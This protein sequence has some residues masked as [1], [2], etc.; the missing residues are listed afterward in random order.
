M[1]QKINVLLVDDEKRFRDTTARLLNKRGLDTKTAAGGAE[2]AEM[3]NEFKFDVV[4][5]DIKMPGMDGHAVLRQIKN[6][7]PDVQVIMLTG[8]G[9]SDSARESLAKD[10]FDYLNKPCDIDILVLKIRDAY[11]A[12]NEDEIRYEKRAK[13]IM[14]HIEDYTK[15]HTDATVK[16]AIMC[17]MDS[18]KNCISSSQIMETG[19]RSLLVLDSNEKI[20]GVLSIFDL[21]E[22]SRPAYLSYPK[23]SMADSMQYSSMFWSGLF[24][25]QIQALAD[26]KVEDIMSDSPPH[27]DENANLMEVSDLM[28]TENLRRVTVKSGDA[29]IGVVREQELFFEMVNIIV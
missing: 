3:L 11:K 13:D 24:T 27:V 12:K 23:P 19:H 2:A 14:I 18:F 15:V 1:S 25:M 9:T 20:V 10:A 17:L 16:D 22:A 29:I 8:H 28:Y 7:F 4:I 6:Q 26:K 5:L 21:I